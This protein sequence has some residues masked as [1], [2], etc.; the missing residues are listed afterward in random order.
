MAHRQLGWADFK[1]IVKFMQAAYPELARTGGAVINFGSG[2]G[3]WAQPTQAAYAAT[4]EVIRGLSRFVANE[5]DADGA[6][7]NVVC[8]I[9][10]TGGVRNWRESA[11]QMYEQALGDIPLGRFG[12]PDTDAAPIVTFLASGD[13]KY[14]TCQTLMTDRGATKLC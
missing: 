14:M 11:S 7:I 4:K 12:D 9:T 10:M 6:R 3:L 2:T 1:A 5:G 13:A 8:P